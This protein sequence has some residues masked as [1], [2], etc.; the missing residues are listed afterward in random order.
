MW[1]D[2]TTWRH[3][4][5]A[6]GPHVPGFA[7]PKHL[8][9]LEEIKKFEKL[10]GSIPKEQ[11]PVPWSG[12]F[13]GWVGRADV[14]PGLVV[15]ISTWILHRLVAYSY[16]Q[17]NSKD[18]VS[19]PYC[20]SDSRWQCNC[21]I[22]C[23]KYV[24]LVYQGGSM[25]PES[26]SDRDSKKY[27]KVVFEHCVGSVDINSKLETSIFQ[28][29]RT[30][31]PCCYLQNPFQTYMN[32]LTFRP[33]SLKWPK[34][35]YKYYKYFKESLIAEKSGETIPDDKLTKGALKLLNDFLFK[36]VSALTSLEF[37]RVKSG[38]FVPFSKSS[39]NSNVVFF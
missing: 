35:I 9:S 20:G 15:R 2:L 17:K 25:L 18:V 37:L 21:G 26:Q 36:S 22:S 14:N 1:E 6:I 38:I 7:H 27:E 10:E 33:P 8:L 32:S 24:P 34:E 29:Y 39:Q 31:L 19:F 28:V 11:E 16:S 4:P 5:E 12:D 3:F 23:V 30:S 13:V